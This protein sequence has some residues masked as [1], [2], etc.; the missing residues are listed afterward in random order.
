MIYCRSGEQAPHCRRFQ[1]KAIADSASSAGAIA[2]PRCAMHS[3][4]QPSSLFFAAFAAAFLAAAIVRTAPQSD[5]PPGGTNGTV[6]QTALAVAGVAAMA[7]ALASSDRP[8]DAGRV[9]AAIGAPASEGSAEPA[10][11]A[12]HPMTMEQRHQLIML[13]IMRETSRHPVGAL[14]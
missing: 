14:R 1:D 6:N 3:H 8:A 4:R 12:V 5:V 2:L 7:P 13:L 10:R 11:A 9:G